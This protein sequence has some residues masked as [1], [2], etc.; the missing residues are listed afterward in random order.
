MQVIKR[1]GPV[2]VTEIKDVKVEGSVNKRLTLRQKFARPN[3]ISELLGKST[4]SDLVSWQTVIPEKIA[5]LGIKEGQALRL[6]SGTPILRITET[7][8]SRDPENPELNL[9]KNPSTGKVLTYKGLPIYRYVD[10]DVV[11]RGVA[12]EMLTHDVVTN[13]VVPSAVQSTGSDDASNK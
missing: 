12:D 2:I 7:T 11:E 1:V 9:K 5:E 6:D 13:T 4:E 8:V 3:A 10:L